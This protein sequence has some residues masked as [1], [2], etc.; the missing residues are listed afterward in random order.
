LRRLMDDGDLRRE[1]ASRARSRTLQL[2]PERMAASIFECYQKL[3]SQQ[4]LPEERD[5]PLRKS[6]VAAQ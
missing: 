6:A 1:M 4:S 2:T 3:S 5:M